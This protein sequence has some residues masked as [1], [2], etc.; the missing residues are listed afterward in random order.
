M[1]DAQLVPVGTSGTTVLFTPWFPRKEDNVRVVVELLA[2]DLGK[3]GVEL[4]H[5][6]SEDVGDGTV[7]TGKIEVSS[8]GRS[9]PQE[10]LGLKELCRFRITATSTQTPVEDGWVLFRLLSP[11]W[12][13]T[14]KA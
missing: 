10:W 1:I 12:F 4:V 6:S 3:V 9:N 8:V 14:V 11:E 7:M 5:K 13:A 2:T